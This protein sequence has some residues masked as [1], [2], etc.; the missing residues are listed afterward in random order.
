MTSPDTE[1]RER[2]ADAHRD[3]ERA[4]DEGRRRLEEAEER[5]QAILNVALDSI[6]TIDE[7]GRIVEFN[8]AAES[9]FGHRREDVLGLPIS[10]V[11]LPPRMRDAHREGMRRYL[12]TGESKVLGRRLELPAMRGD[13]SEFPVELTISEFEGGERRLFTGYL[14]DITD[15]KEAEEQLKTAKEQAEAANR[16]KTEFLATVSHELRTPLN[17]IVGMADL[18][19]DG[20]LGKG[21]AEPLAAIQRNADALLYLIND[22]LDV[23]RA[24]AGKLELG[25]VSFDPRD[26]ASG[27]QQALAPEAAGKGLTF[28]VAVSG[29]IPA[30]L[31]GDPQRIRQ[32][33]TNLAQNGIKFTREG[34]VTVRLSWR[35]GEPGHL[36][37]EVSDTGPG[38]TE[39]DRQRIF[40]RFYQVDG[41]PSRNEGGVGL[42]LSIAKVLVDMMEGTVE[43][44][45]TLGQGTAFTVL[46]PLEEAAAD[47]RQETLVASRPQV[48]KADGVRVLAVDDTSD[49]RLLV[50]AILGG[51]G[52]DV[53]TVAS[54]G[55]A[56]AL[57]DRELFD[58]VL[59]DIEMPVM[60]GFETTRR[61][62]QLEQRRKRQPVPVVAVSAHAIEGYRER[63]L[64]AGM[65]DYL[66]KPIRRKL[67][68]AKTHSW[69]KSMA[70]GPPVDEDSSGIAI[71]PEI[72]DLIPEFLAN[73]RADAE[74]LCGLAEAA[75]FDEI[76]KLAHKL[77]GV[78]TP[79]G[80]P[81]ITTVA[82]RLETVAADE[83]ADR[84]VSLAEH[85]RSYLEGLL[86]H[87]TAS[88]DR[89]TSS[90][91][92]KE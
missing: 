7:D 34:R 48:T 18:M 86:P 49:G 9:T 13:G 53:S 73:R 92:T 16:A 88:V 55:D 35:G 21:S 83:D 84:C 46:L 39:D 23:S 71:D 45:S 44:E 50:D 32:V 89:S 2:L 64:A 31:V 74:T 24:E 41:S 5:R 6:V 14:R 10:D 1:L 69:G 60:D 68:I 56:L 43:V 57:L 42:G 72:A 67:L 58:V 66:T 33:I 29:A 80:F 40:E 91:S 25:V 65:N 20:R 22:L 54:G 30:G 28:E 82:G 59:M 76:R 15:Q 47:W 12:R 62:R 36:S 70:M 63:C 37:I 78:G 81:V 61:L 19:A 17:V 4:R 79:Y 27:I 26:L 90:G 51:A 11:I 75:E 77:K 38:L 3:L 87:F 8:P 85:L 52:F